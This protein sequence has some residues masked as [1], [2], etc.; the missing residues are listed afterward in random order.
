MKGNRYHKKKN[1]LNQFL[2]GYTYRYEPLGPEITEKALALQT[3]WCT[4]RDC[5]ASDMLSAEN[6]VIE[7][8]LKNWSR[9][10]GPIRGRAA[11]Q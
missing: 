10:E 7:K 11:G 5:E 9:L 4:W 8:V 2:A 3:D 1:L 6:R